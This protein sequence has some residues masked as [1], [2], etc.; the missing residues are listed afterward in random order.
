MQLTF[1]ELGSSSSWLHDIL[2]DGIVF[3]FLFLFSFHLLLA[4][5][6]RWFNF[7]LPTTAPFPAT[8]VTASFHLI[9]LS[10]SVFFKAFL[11]QQ[12]KQRKMGYLLSPFLSAISLAYHVGGRCPQTRLP[13]VKNC[14]TAKAKAKATA[15]ATP[16][17]HTFTLSLIQW[18]NPSLIYTILLQLPT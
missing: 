13:H 5:W 3:L 14:G 17:S 7:P 16:D 10:D 9:L 8:C 11:P 4:T 1:I 2:H 15:T 12:R 6:T 18:E